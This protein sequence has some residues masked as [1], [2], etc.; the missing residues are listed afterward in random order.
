LVARANVYLS[1][2]PD[3]NQVAGG[4]SKQLITRREVADLYNS[5]S[6]IT[7]RLVERLRQ[8]PGGYGQFRR[9][10]LLGHPPGEPA[11]HSSPIDALLA[12]LRPWSLKQVRT[13]FGRLQR[14]GFLTAIR[15]HGNG[16]WRYRLPEELA[17]V[18]SPFRSLPRIE[19]M[20][21]GQVPA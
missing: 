15:E 16:P 13:H 21:A 7:R 3:A 5:R 19:R 9:L 17:A 10:G 8:M 4:Q 11:W 14:D 12:A 20:A 1:V 2:R 6:R 18:S